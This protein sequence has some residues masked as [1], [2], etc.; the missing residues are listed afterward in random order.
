MDN[1]DNMGMK[2]H[3]AVKIGVLRFLSSKKVELQVMIGIYTNETHNIGG[4]V[5]TT[6]HH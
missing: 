2:K 4:M 6:N 5:I 1:M 3:L